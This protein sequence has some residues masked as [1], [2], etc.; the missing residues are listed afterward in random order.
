MIYVLM[1]YTAIAIERPITGMPSKIIVAHYIWYVIVGAIVQAISL[2][3]RLWR[4]VLPQ[5]QYI[6]IN[7]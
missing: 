4:N 7:M 2:S 5:T 6:I 1:D 3:A